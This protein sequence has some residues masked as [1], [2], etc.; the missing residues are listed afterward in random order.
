MTF[1]SR[2][3]SHDFS[4]SP[5]AAELQRDSIRMRFEP[6]L[7][8]QFIAAY[9][10]HLRFRVRFWWLTGLVVVP[11]FTIFFSPHVRLLSIEGTFH[12]AFIVLL[13]AAA[14]LVFSSHVAARYGGE[15]FAVLLYDLAPEHHLPAR[16]T[17]PSGYTESIDRTRRLR[18]REGIDCQYRRGHRATRIR[19]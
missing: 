13:T 7:E 8:S 17:A 3:R 11:I 1:L 4:D 10:E 16:R 19:T 2:I 14:C 18:G 9:L 6:K 5:Y 15:E 12:V